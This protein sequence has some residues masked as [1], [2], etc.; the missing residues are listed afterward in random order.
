M[1]LP[2][3]GPWIL[4]APFLTWETTLGNDLFIFFFNFL[5]SPSCFCTKG[6]AELAMRELGGLRWG[7][8]RSGQLSVR[9][10]NGGFKEC[11]LCMNGH[12][13]F[14]VFMRNCSEELNIF[15]DVEQCLTECY[16]GLRWDHCS[17]LLAYYCLQQCLTCCKC[18]INICWMNYHHPGSRSISH[19]SKAIDMQMYTFNYKIL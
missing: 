6:G 3:L 8:K 10:A 11:V 15:L 17:Q 9:V 5:I 7:G 2:G 18:L 16:T 4:V 13:L 19:E 12:P 14:G 1:G